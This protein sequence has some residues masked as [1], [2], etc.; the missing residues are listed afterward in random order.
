MLQYENLAMKQLELQIRNNINDADLSVGS[1]YWLL[2]SLTLE[3]ETLYNTAA[4]NEQEIY[5]N[6]QQEESSK[7]NDE[8]MQQPLQWDVVVQDTSES[9]DSGQE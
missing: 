7:L 2:K 3:I 6:Q 9:K 5:L 8:I 4:Q 1:V